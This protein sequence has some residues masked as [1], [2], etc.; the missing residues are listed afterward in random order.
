MPKWLKILLGL[1]VS[2]AIFGG[3]AA[4][5]FDAHPLRSSFNLEG[6][7]E[8]SRYSSEG[9]S[10]CYDDY[11]RETDRSD[12]QERLLAAAVGA[13]AVGL[14]WLLAYFFYFRRRR[15]ASADAAE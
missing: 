4:A 7:V 10:H 9:S 12:S 2:V 1:V 6:C 14:F 5:V 13:A 15:A 11:R 3:V 8:D